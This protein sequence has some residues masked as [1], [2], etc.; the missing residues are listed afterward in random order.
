M[1]ELSTIAV[2][3]DGSG[4]S[5]AAFGQAC[6]VAKATQA[7]VVL[8]HAIPAM[9]PYFERALFPFAAMGEDALGIV[10]ELKA[11]AVAQVRATHRLDA[12][13]AP[14]DGDEDEDA[15]PRKDADALTE[16]MEDIDVAALAS[17]DDSGEAALLGEWL[18]GLG[19]ELV[20][21]GASGASGPTPG[22]LGSVAERVAGSCGA[23]L[24][25]A[26]A[27]EGRRPVRRVA[28]AVDLS[29]A[30][31][32]VYRSAVALALALEADLHVV[33]VVPSLLAQDLGGPL[34][35]ALRADP[36]SVT[37]RAAKDVQ[38]R[39][40]RL[41]DGLEVPFASQPAREAMRE[42]VA[43][44]EGDPTEALLAY[45]DRAGI[46]V[47]VLGRRGHGVAS[48]PLRLGRT[49]RALLACAPCHAVVIP[50][51]GAL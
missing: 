40:A 13:A 5:R 33:V 36:A 4:G 24:W 42:V 37:K 26:R 14:S 2:L 20:M 22:V 11:H 31:A 32:G 25:V 10:E 9:L 8:A 34:S 49:A 16:G 44:E 3:T 46:D 43:V 28:A 35:A 19:P 23:P 38:R 21:M 41:R 47:L 39:L 27:S 48:L 17:L 6:G 7:R 50:P 29:E 12:T 45:I 30:S 1:L 15:A 18:T 51:G